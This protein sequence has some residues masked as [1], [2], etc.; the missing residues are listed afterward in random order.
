MTSFQIKSRQWYVDKGRKKYKQ[1]IDE[2]YTHEHDSMFCHDSDLTGLKA[3]FILFWESSS[4]LYDITLLFITKYNYYLFELTWCFV[5]FN[6]QTKIKSSYWRSFLF[7]FIKQMNR[8]VLPM[9]SSLTSSFTKASQYLYNNKCGG[10]KQIHKYLIG[11]R[12][13]A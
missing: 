13:E 8:N 5:V 1:S 2:L 10:K 9:L 3:C 12:N 11:T 7:L 6:N 4:L